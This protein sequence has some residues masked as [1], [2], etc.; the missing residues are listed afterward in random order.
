[1]G[2]AL[3]VGGTKLSDSH[4]E[5]KKVSVTLVPIGHI[6]FMVCAKSAVGNVSMRDHI[7]K[8]NISLISAIDLYPS[9]TSL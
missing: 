6:F 3:G 7:S 5:I 9:S 8:L 1:L 2:A 4:L